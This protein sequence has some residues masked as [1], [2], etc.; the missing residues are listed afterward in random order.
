MK[1]TDGYW[2]RRP[3][4]HAAHPVEVRDVTEEPGKLTVHAPARPIRHRVDTLLGPLATI[5]YSS[6]LPDVIGV[7]ITH[8]AGEVPRG[9]RFEL[10]EDPVLQDIEVTVDESAAR[11]TS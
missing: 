4:V 2:R 8:F 1:F 10:Q 3:G 5:T 11:L 7:K 9:P 6:P